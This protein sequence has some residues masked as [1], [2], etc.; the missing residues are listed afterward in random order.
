MKY[1]NSLGFDALFFLSREEGKNQKNSRDSERKQS[2]KKSEIQ[3]AG[4]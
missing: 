3:E 2:M 4:E 1:K